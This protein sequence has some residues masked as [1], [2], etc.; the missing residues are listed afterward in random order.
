MLQR[1]VVW[2]LSYLYKCNTSV[3]TVTSLEAMFPNCINLYV[4]FIVFYNTKN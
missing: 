2:V 3:S 4:K 1:T